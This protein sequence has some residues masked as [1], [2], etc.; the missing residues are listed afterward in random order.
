VN[1]SKFW[2]NVIHT[3]LSKDPHIY[4]YVLTDVKFTSRLLTSLRCHV[5]IT[6]LSTARDAGP[7][8]HASMG[9]PAYAKL[10]ELHLQLNVSGALRQTKT[11]STN[12]NC[13]LPAATFSRHT[14]YSYYRLGSLRIGSQIEN[15]RLRL[16]RRCRVAEAQRPSRTLSSQILLMCYRVIAR[17]PKISQANMC[18]TGCRPRGV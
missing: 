12:S 15:D 4:M 17:M 18:V 16:Q 6:C 13:R 10:N 5:P 11:S 2:K 9:T 1:A 7:E 8:K 14:H 3:I